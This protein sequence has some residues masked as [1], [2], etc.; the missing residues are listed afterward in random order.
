[1]RGGEG[2]EGRE[3]GERREGRGGEGPLEHVN[4][5]EWDIKFN[6]QTAREGLAKAYPPQSK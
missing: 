3:R 5:S 1:M 6:G 4:V 2:R